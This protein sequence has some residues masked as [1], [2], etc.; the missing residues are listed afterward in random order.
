MKQ[1]T[2]QKLLFT[3]WYGV[4]LLGAVA[5]YAQSGVAI[6][7]DREVGC[8]FYSVD[9]EDRKL[10]L[11]DIVDGHCLRACE[12][13]TV[14]YMLTG[15][16]GLVPH[17][18]WTVTGGT[19]IESTDSTCT[20]EW[21]TVGNGG[22]TFVLTTPNGV[23]NKYICIEKISIPKAS[24]NVT[25]VTGYV[26]DPEFPDAP[27]PPRPTDIY[28][29]AQQTIYFENN[30]TVNNGSE[31][32]SYFW[33][34]A[35]GSTSTA[36][37]PDHAYTQE[38]D[39]EVRLTVYNK[40]NCSAVFRRTVHV[41]GHGGFEIQCPGVVCEGEVVTYS[42]PF[43]G[44][45]ICEGKYV[46]NVSGSTTPLV[47]NEQNG[48]ATVTWNNVGPD[49]FGY[50]TFVPTDCQLTCLLPTT[51]KIPVITS[52]GTIHGDATVCART[53]A[54][55]S[56][57]QWPSTDF[58][59]K[60]LEDPDG[61]LV[62][63]LPTDQRN[64]IVVYPQQPGTY[65]LMATYE[66]TLLHCGGTAT[67]VITVSESTDFE[68]PTMICQ[69]TT[70]SYHT[71]SG[72]PTSWV[73]RNNNGT[74]IAV[75]PSPAAAFTYTFTIAGDYSLSVGASGTCPSQQKNIKVIGLPAPPSAA[76]IMV[77]NP[78]IVSDPP[79]YV[80]ATSLKVCPN[81][82]YSYKASNSPTTV[83]HWSVVNG[84]IDGS[85]IGNEVIITFSGV[86][87]AQIFI[88]KQTIAPIPCTSAPLPITI[89]I[90]KIE[91]QIN[92]GLPATVCAN[93]YKNFVANVIS[94]NT[95]Y[96][97][98][99]SYTWSIENPALGSIT[100]GQNT[101][102]I[103]VLWNN[104][105]EPTTTKLL[106]TIT[107][108]TL[109]IPFY[110]DVTITPVPDI[111]VT[112]SPTTVCS[113]SPIAFNVTDLNGYNITSG[114]ATWN[115]GS[116]NAGGSIT[117]NQYTYTNTSIANVGHNV[118]VSITN[119]NGCTGTTNT[120]N[121][122]VVVLPGP[123]AAASL[124]T[125]VNTFC[126]Q[127]DIAATLTVA[128]T[129]TSG[130]T[131]QWYNGSTL[132]AGQ[133][134]TTLTVTPAM[135]FGTY[136][137]IA[138]NSLYCQT[139]SN[140][141][142]IQQDC[143]SQS[144][145]YEGSHDMTNTSQFEC[146]ENGNY[147]N[148][149]GTASGT[150]Q[151]VNWAIY[152]PPNV[153]IT[154]YQGTTFTPTKAGE[155]HTFC[156][157]YYLNANGELCPFDAA[158]IVVVPYIPDFGYNKECHDNNTFDITLVDKTSFFAL[159]TN[160]TI[161]YEYRLGNTGSWTPV[162]GTTISGLAAG[163]Y[164]VKVT[165]NGEYPAGTAQPTCEK[166][167]TVS[168]ATIPDQSISFTP[169]PVDCHDTS[170]KFKLSEDENTT[171]SYMWTFEPGAQSTLYLT[172]RVFSSSGSKTV[173]VTITNKYGC[174]V[175]KNTTVVIP[176]KCFNGTIASTP[177]DPKVCTGSSI[178]LKYLPDTTAP[179]IDNCTPLTYTWMKGQTPI[180]GN[181][182]TLTIT[183]LGF[184]WVNV[185]KGLCKYDTPNR[186]TPVFYP[187]PSI[188]L[189]GPSAVCDNEGFTVHATANT[190]QLNWSLVY[191][192]E[193]RPLPAFQDN[194][195][196]QLSDLAPGVYTVIAT[197]TAANGC[198]ASAAHTVT[199]N[200]APPAPV[201]SQ[202]VICPG[203]N[204]EIPYYHINLTA[205]SEVDG[206]FT[207]SNGVSG[208][209]QT[210]TDGGPY[211]VRIT[212]NGCSSV[213]QIDVPKSPDNFMWVFPSGCQTACTRD[214]QG[215]L[216]GPSQPVTTWTWWLNE[217]I[218]STGTG[219]TEPLPV[220]ANGTYNLVL[221]ANNCT[222]V[223]KPLTYTAKLCD[224]CDIDSVDILGEITRRNDGFC[225]FNL[226]LKI[227]SNVTA[228]VTF[229]AP[230]NEVVVLPSAFTVNA[231][232]NEYPFVIIPVAPNFQGGDIQL[233]LTATDDGRPCNYE[234]TVHLPACGQPTGGGSKP[235]AAA[236]PLSIVLAPNPA[237][238]Q[239]TMHY[240]GLDSAAEVT[241][242]DL[243]G[244]KVASYH[245]EGTAGEL[246]MPTDSYP[247]GVYIVTVRSK[248]GLLSQQKLV[249]E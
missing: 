144:C 167:F 8:Q 170:V 113:G 116:G 150:P 135:G 20:I 35:D 14:T 145:V 238:A 191:N 136:Y 122:N 141:V 214:G 85:P 142:I 59:W 21:G 154:G 13:S 206:V 31:L 82:P 161:T 204:P 120:A 233:V 52:R 131:Y 1:K 27:P 185:A 173:S 138:T 162:S 227:D 163:N 40:C 97:Q 168:L 248:N 194:P 53:Q 26:F 78:D 36:F 245:T 65:T 222:F 87:P 75:S 225:S 147:I 177:S 12:K 15:D 91:A 207:W 126:L 98:G 237:K 179:D 28:A 38:G 187:L 182:P 166:I 132:L 57:P 157:G 49:G 129:I 110:I 121:V 46:W 79:T 29:C 215:T 223:S 235:G 184:Y 67:F 205:T 60:I 88:D 119:P 48:S 229:T 23:I 186:I 16:L 246:L 54:I 64:Q 77:L 58:H 17:T 239:V 139:T 244:R 44:Q 151:D 210:V 72:L 89:P 3:L 232:I 109:S 133:T 51:V 92:D 34:F 70:A 178:T 155:F 19:V 127:A 111:K 18:Q 80:P 130:N 143:G 25:T 234:F 158:K 123:P 221:Q 93:S 114:T 69:N 45:T 47:V 76:N 216:I 22:L 6:T 73:L 197:A 94:S 149:I 209:H 56:L 81:A 101:N 100:T 153:S 118:T 106:L 4:L 180:G 159:V 193:N 240:Q 213:E 190:T 165:A 224:K 202:E 219:L 86:E 199:I 203:Q 32:V 124:S 183:T 192:Q 2:M 140:G 176:E 174:T 108:C 212:A 117:N 99:E 71:S 115:Y 217:A 107:K 160:P 156:V 10:V 241:L 171:D 220:N 37:E 218:L 55:Y 172:Q 112:A 24:F 134:G 208:D 66:N 68:G 5:S 43:A 62:E 9:A 211:Q 125:A 247:S 83:Y 201:I 137:F 105:S 42:L 146:D 164:Q 74:I 96:N 226:I 242:Y 84:T 95:L 41:E 188:K 195:Y 103:S 33:D 198:S 231:G 175:T 11:E 50:L 152:G 249:I 243:T 30:S 236:N 102:S 181:T 61:T 128:S 63:L 104:V 39:Y 200:N 228:A 148:L 196:L 189:D 7:W 169:N 230:N 90:K